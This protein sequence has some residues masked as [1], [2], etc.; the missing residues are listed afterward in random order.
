MCGQKGGECMVRSE[1]AEPLFVTGIPYFAGGMEAALEVTLRAYGE[2]RALAVFT[3]GATVAARAVRDGSLRD[4]LSRADLLLP[5]GKGV[6]LAARACGAGRL[7][8]VAGIDFAERLLAA[9]E[10]AGARVFLYGGKPGVA[11]RAAVRLG[12]RYPRLI[13]ATADGYGRDPRE[14]IAAFR[15]HAV[16]VGLGVPRQEVWIAENKAR[17]GGVLMG[18][19]GALDVWAGDKK[20]AP[21]PLRR[22]GL[23]WAWRTVCEPHRLPRLFPLPRYY[24]TCLRFRQ[25]A[26]KKK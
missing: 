6:T 24:I 4:L 16:C 9:M 10:G 14:R 2:G 25:N 3:P 23:E 18:I 8:A 11:E 20:R 1:G 22:A 19:G 17:T 5:D 15:P 7:S 26:K 13:F 12:E 21:A